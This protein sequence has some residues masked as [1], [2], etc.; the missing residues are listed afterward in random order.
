[1]ENCL[2]NKNSVQKILKGSYT[3]ACMHKEMN[4]MD[5]NGAPF[6]ARSSCLNCVHV[7]CQY[8]LVPKDQHSLH[9]LTFVSQL[10]TNDWWPPTNTHVWENLATEG[11]TLSIKTQR[12]ASGD[13]TC[14]LDFLVY[15]FPTSKT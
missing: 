12:P 10:R 5:Q 8:Q 15:W 2:K 14:R 3:I 4:P 1:M 13:D 11:Q 7:A 9:L 6:N